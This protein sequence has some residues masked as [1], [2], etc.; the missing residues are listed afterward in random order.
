[1]GW[2][3]RDVEKILCLDNRYV[4]QVVLNR[5]INVHMSIVHLQ[6]EREFVFGQFL[7]FH[8]RDHSSCRIIWQIRVFNKLPQQKT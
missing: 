8:A 7:F 5:S 3:A 1:M 6:L 4:D 2:L